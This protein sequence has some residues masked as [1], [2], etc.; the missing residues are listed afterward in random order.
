MPAEYIFT[1]TN[2]PDPEGDNSGF[3]QRESEWQAASL[4]RTS[5]FNAELCAHLIRRPEVQRQQQ[6]LLPGPQW[7]WLSLGRAET[8]Q[9]GGRATHTGI[10]FQ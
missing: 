4:A 10:N 3:V 8:L 7:S 1:S 2:K 9:T 5:S 6:A